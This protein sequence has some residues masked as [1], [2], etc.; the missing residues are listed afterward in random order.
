MDNMTSS[1][2]WDTQES[3][4]YEANKTVIDKNNKLKFRTWYDAVP[5]NTGMFSGRVDKIFLDGTSN[6]LGD[7]SFLQ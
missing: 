3:K 2:D 1:K 7:A 4:I 6:Q 5:F